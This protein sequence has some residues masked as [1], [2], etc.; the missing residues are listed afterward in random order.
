MHIMNLA[1]EIARHLHGTEARDVRIE[2][3]GGAASA[4][5]LG[6]LSDKE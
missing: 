6:G 1:E 2:A 3:G 4:G 5:I